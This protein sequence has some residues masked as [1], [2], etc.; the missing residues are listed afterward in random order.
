MTLIKDIHAREVLDSRGMP[1]IEANVLLANGMIGRGMV[2]AGAS[3][4]DKEA[5]EL[6]DGGKRYLGKGVQQ[7]IANIEQYIK[8]PLLG[9]SVLEQTQ[10]D[11]LMLKLDGT[12]NKSKLGANAI[13]ALSLAIADA[14]AKYEQLPLYAYLNQYLKTDLS[15]PLPMMNIINGGAHADNNLDIQEFMIVPHGV[16]SFKESLRYGVEVFQ[17]LKSLLKQ[18]SLVTAVGDE[19]GFAPNLSSNAQAI[20]LILEAIHI[21]GFKVDTEVSL[22]LDVAANEFYSSQSKIYNLRSEAK[23]LSS[24]Q[25]IEYLA[26]LA[27]QYPIFSIEDGLSEYDWHGWKLLTHR[28]GDSLQLVGDDLFVTNTTLLAQGINNAVANAILIKINQIGTLTETF[29][30]I[31]MA[32]Q[33]SYNCIV[34]HRSGETEDTFIADFAVATDVKQI[35][36]GSLTRSERIAKY[37]QLLRIEENLANSAQFSKLSILNGV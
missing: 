10:I 22:A 4:G 15:L 33:A 32:K 37:N 21:A 23:Q 17:S 11:N 29:A 1:T 5:L 34:S 26:N 8:T 6:R 31:E 36:T 7:A 27:A 16:D 24:E 28:L 2:P 19:G 20:E 13:L 12:P 30:A 25:F 18:Q 3:T 14:A 9:M 35:K